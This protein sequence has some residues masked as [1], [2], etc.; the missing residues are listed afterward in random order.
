[1][2][3]EAEKEAGDIPTALKRDKPRYSFMDVV[4]NIS[5]K[6]HK[7]FD[8][9]F[10]VEICAR[11]IITS[12]DLAATLVMHKIFELDLQEWKLS[13]LLEVFSSSVKS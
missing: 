3:L 13:G 5:A 7:I 4:S 6:P 12:A 10:D 11:F 2:I 1:M 9:P 8:S